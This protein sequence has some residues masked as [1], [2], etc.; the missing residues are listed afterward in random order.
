[1]R[2]ASTINMTNLYYDDP[3]ETFVPPGQNRDSRC[4]GDPPPC[5]QSKRGFSPM[6]EQGIGFYCWRRIGPRPRAYAFI[7]NRWRLPNFVE[8]SVFQSP[9]I[10]NITRYIPLVAL[11][12]EV[13]TTHAEDMENDRRKSYATRSR[14]KSYMSRVLHVPRTNRSCTISTKPGGEPSPS[15]QQEDADAILTEQP[16]GLLTAWGL[17]VHS[18]G[19]RAQKWISLQG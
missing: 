14:C 12:F 17:S 11:D 3:R 1:M 15:L 2:F 16:A 8:T 6:R 19:W 18:T 9:T 10:R 4:G 7:S 5:L 13:L